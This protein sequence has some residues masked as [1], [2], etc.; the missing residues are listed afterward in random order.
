MGRRNLKKTPAMER[1]EIFENE[2]KTLDFLAKFIQDQ[3]QQAIAER[4][5]FVVG[6]SGGSLCSQLSR[7]LPGIATEWSK[8]KLL[9]C[10]ER[11]VPFDNNESTFKAYKEKL[12]STNLLTEDQFLT[13]KP[14]LPAVEAALDYEQQ[15]RQLY[16]DVSLP[17]IDLLLLGVGPDGHTCSLFPG[18]A[19]LEET[20][21]WV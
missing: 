2:G 18:H 19:L 6:L 7:A 8:W 3:A 16:P 11:V 21:K 5:A 9:S 1:V 13:I 10:D 12:C 14:E 17:K 15:L 20:K 4:K